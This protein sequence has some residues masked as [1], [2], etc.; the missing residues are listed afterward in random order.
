MSVWRNLPA[1]RAVYGESGELVSVSVEVPA[2]ELE[3]LLEAL[4]GAR[5]PINP[6]IFHPRGAGPTLVEFPA[7]A[8]DLD[9]V[10]RVLSHHGFDANRLRISGILETLAQ[11]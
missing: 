8:G 7:Y 10:R 2:H 9:E 3:E 1:H 5:F 4:A 6:E 11:A